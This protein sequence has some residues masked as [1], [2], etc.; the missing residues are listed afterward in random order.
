MA[1]SVRAGQAATR[2]AASSIAGAATTMQ[3]PPTEKLACREAC[4]TE[5]EYQQTDDKHFH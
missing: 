2:G 3:R 1:A 4:A 5:H